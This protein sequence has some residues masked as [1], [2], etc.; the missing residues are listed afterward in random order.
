VLGVVGVG[1]AVYMIARTTGIHLRVVHSYF[2]LITVLLMICT[3]LLGHFMLKIRMNPSGVKRARAVHRWIGR[4]T[5]LLMAASIGL[6]LSQVW[7]MLF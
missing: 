7:V 3:P 6:G 2:G 4:V 5:L 1:L